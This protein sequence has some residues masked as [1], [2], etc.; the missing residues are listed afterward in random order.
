MTDLTASERLLRSL[1][2]PTYKPRP[3]TEKATKYV[4]NCV[5][6]EWRELPKLYRC[7]LRITGRGLRWTLRRISRLIDVIEMAPIPFRESVPESAPE[8]AP[9]QESESTPESVS[10]T[11]P[12]EVNQS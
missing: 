5:R 9:V 4:A 10:E 8:T 6:H 1:F 11:V 3:L 7:W 12:E 2:D